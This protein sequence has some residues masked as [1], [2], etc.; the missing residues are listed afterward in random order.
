MRHGSEDFSESGVKIVVEWFVKD[1][2]LE[3]KAEI[4]LVLDN[5]L[6]QSALQTLYKSADLSYMVYMVQ[7]E[8]VNCPD[9]I[10]NKQ[11]PL[12]DNF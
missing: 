12:I 11:D 8:R 10:A 1:G 3:N 5:K 2:E 7:S 4:L 6:C 9:G